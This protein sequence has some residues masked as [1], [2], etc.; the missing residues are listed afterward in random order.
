MILE[1]KSKQENKN[2]NPLSR[3]KFLKMIGISSAGLAAGILFKDLLNDREKGREKY[4][5]KFG[6]IKINT[7]ELA[8]KKLGGL[9]K[10]YLG[11]EDSIVPKI[12]KVD[13]EKQLKTLWQMKEEKSGLTRP[14]EKTRD[15]L[16][17]EY[18]KKRTGMDLEMYKNEATSSVENVYNNLNWEKAGKK[19]KLNENKIDLLKE[20][21]KEIK[22]SEILA[23]SLTELMPS[24][25]GEINVKILDLLL[26]NAGREFVES[27]P[28][29]YDHY[30]SFGPF[31]FTHYS[32]F[33]DGKKRE[34]A[35]K[36]AEFL[37]IDNFPSSV[38]N[39]RGNQNFEAA[40]LFA[41]YNLIL[42]IKS[43]SSANIEKIKK[44]WNKNED[45][46]IQYIATAHNKPADA[47]KAARRWIDNDL[48][49]DYSISCKKIPLLYAK[50]TKSN[51]K[52]IKEYFK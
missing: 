37:N 33:N 10:H 7:N 9:Y 14:A 28:A 48:K 26:K 3:R 46:L 44:Y 20:F 16:F 50:K 51:Y 43:L 17:E 35:S 21:A 36:L 15:N 47:R 8:G 31:Q 4:E 2:S 52:A 30:T 23:Y 13:F 38:T 49:S 24:D 27:I 40:Y 18:N 45:D 29:V 39:I 5:I 25:T 34:G 42:L 41:I 22:G 6:E 11:L 19:F 12:L 32:I 1:N